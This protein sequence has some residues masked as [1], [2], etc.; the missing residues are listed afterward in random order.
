LTSL[1]VLLTFYGTI[2][3]VIQL[4]INVLS[5]LGLNTQL[6]QTERRI[7]QNLQRIEKLV[8]RSS[9]DQKP[10]LLKYLAEISKK[11]SSKLIGI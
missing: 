4:T 10:L 6:N 8:D 1:G 9:L 5:L 11:Y 7:K 3:S 2:E